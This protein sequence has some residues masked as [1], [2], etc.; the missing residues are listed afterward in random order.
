V[1]PGDSVGWA[2]GTTS[3]IA[4][5]ALDAAIAMTGIVVLWVDHLDRQWQFQEA[6]A[7]SEGDKTP[8]LSLWTDRN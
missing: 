8:V 1:P 4:L 2:S 7:D 6:T 5:P 3:I